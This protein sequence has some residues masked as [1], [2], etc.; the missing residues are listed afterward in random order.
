M[1]DPFDLELRSKNRDL[2]LFLIVTVRMRKGRFH[3]GSDQVY[4]SCR[5]AFPCD[6]EMDAIVSWQIKSH[7]SQRQFF[8]SW[9]ELV[10]VGNSCHVH[11]DI[12]AKRRIRATTDFCYDHLF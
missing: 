11:G 9:F 6:C 2:Y 10:S 12:Q 3:N 4:A 5:Y 1:S 8:D 7:H